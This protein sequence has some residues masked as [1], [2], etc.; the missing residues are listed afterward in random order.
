[1][2]VINC[3]EINDALQLIAP[4]PEHVP[5][6]CRAA[7]ARVW[8]DL[9]MEESGE[10]AITPD[11]QLLIDPALYPDEDTIWVAGSRAS[12]GP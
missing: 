2:K 3:F 7:D 11:L 12:F 8:V 6:A 9:R 4:A 10:I 5:E 1:M